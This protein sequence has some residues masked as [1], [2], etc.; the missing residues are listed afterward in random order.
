[1]TTFAQM[2]FAAAVTA[3]SA[4]PSVDGYI[5][6]LVANGWTFGIHP[7][8]TPVQYAALQ[9]AIAASLVTVNPYVAPPAPPPP[10]LAHQA[11]A[12]LPD[13]DTTMHRIAEAVALGLNAWTGADVIAWV[14]YRRELRAIA[15]GTSAA[16][17]LPAA[18]AYPTGT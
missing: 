5:G 18:P 9:A 10:A 6:T 13:T 7:T 8:A 11:A 14:T 1:M 12:M 15:N 2:G 16:T 3:A 17:A 4:T